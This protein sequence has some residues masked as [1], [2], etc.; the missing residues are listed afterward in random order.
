MI[1]EMPLFQAIKQKMQWHQARQ[2]VLA[3]NVANAETPGYAA[4]DLKPF[5]FEQQRRDGSFANVQTMTTNVR[6][7]AAASSG[8]VN[9]FG[10]TSV[11]HY[12]VTPEGNGVTLEDQMMNVVQ[13]QMDY[14]A[15]TALYTRSVKLIKTALGRSA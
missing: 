15:V 9:G 2:G 4:R 13:N 10:A 3:E 6:H 11:A 14:Q 1:G 8:G 5:D 7:I 12:E